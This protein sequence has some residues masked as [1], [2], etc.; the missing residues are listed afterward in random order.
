[1]FFLSEDQRALQEAARRFAQEQIVPQAQ[2]Y[3]SSADFPLDI[4]NQAYE[5]GF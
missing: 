3:D 4:I 5:L 2:K 1:M